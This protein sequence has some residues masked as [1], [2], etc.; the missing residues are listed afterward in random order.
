MDKEENRINFDMSLLSLEQLIE[1]YNDIDKFIKYIN[2]T[3][4]KSISFKNV[5]LYGGIVI[6]F[7]SFW[8]C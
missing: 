4:K 8:I 2:S 1:V 5:L 3:G 7:F 6:Y